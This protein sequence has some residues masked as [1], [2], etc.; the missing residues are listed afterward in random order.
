[1][2]RNYT[3]PCQTC[4]G[5]GRWTAQRTGGRPQKCSLCNGTGWLEAGKPAE[6]PKG[7]PVPPES[8]AENPS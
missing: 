2:R 3:G 8:E 1:M 6:P 5:T 4:G 7:E